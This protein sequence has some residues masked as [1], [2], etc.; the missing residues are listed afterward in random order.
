MGIGRREVF[1]KVKCDKAENPAQSMR[2]RIQKTARV[3][4]K[5]RRG[6]IK[7]IDG[8]FLEK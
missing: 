7:N 3:P 4:L 6:K 1:F 8:S 2:E 5:E